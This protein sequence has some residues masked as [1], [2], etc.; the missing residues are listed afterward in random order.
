MPVIN[1]TLHLVVDCIKGPVLFLSLYLFPST[2]NFAAS[3]CSVG[4]VKFPSLGLAM[5]LSLLTNGILVDKVKA[6]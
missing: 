4:G 5:C 1:R 2:Y 6:Y 3:F